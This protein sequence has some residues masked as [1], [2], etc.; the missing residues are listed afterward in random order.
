MRDPRGSRRRDVLVGA[1]S[2]VAWAAA[3]GCAGTD[4]TPDP[5]SGRAP[6]PDAPWQGLGAPDTAAF[7]LG[8]QSGDPAPDGAVLWT[9]YAGAEGLEVIVAAYANGAW[10]EVATL[11]AAVA[12]GGYVH[13]AADGLDSDT[14]VGFQF[15][16][17]AGA[18]SSVGSC[19]T[20]IGADSTAPVV[21]GATSCLNMVHGDFPCLNRVVERGPMDAFLQV[22]DTVYADGSTTLDDYRSAWAQVLATAGLS[23]VSQAVAQ[24][25]TWDDHEVDNNWNSDGASEDLVA[26]AREAFFESTPARRDPDHP[27]RIWRQLRF[28]RTA[29]VFVLDCRG[30]RDDVAGTYVSAEQLDWLLEGLSASQATWK[31]IVNSV[32]ITD[33]PLAYEVDDVVIDR[34]E[35]YPAQRR[36]LLDGIAAAGVDGVLFVAGD[37]HHPGLY[38]VDAEGST[39]NVWEAL[40]GPAG[41]TLNPLGVLIEDGDQYYWSDAVWCATRFE[42]YADGRARIVVVGEEDETWFD[43][44]LTAQGELLAAH[45]VHS[46][47]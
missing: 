17:A 28:G 1:G 38:R 9:K 10:D 37:F 13:V 39:A 11:S 18:L 34:W 8:V 15:R 43:G 12:D 41:S 2:V 26:T 3:V 24:V 35:G 16:D 7:P 31:L 21:I 6:A 40:T 32:P 36:E 42:L 27:E 5:T 20:A 30:E 44:I 19:R 14:P 29:D 33:M 4:T 25:H 22:G 46:S 47:P 23:A 45:V